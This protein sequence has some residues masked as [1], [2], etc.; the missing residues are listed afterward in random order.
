[1]RF[2]GVLVWLGGFAGGRRRGLGTGGGE[3]SGD[4][5]RGSASCDPPA[6]GDKEVAT[7]EEVL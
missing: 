7:E 6:K 1:M 5:E 3:E 2:D 4:V